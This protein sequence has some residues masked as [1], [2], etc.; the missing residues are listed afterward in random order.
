LTGIVVLGSYPQGDI[1]AALQLFRNPF[2]TKLADPGKKYIYCSR[3]SHESETPVGLTVSHEGLPTQPTH[4]LVSALDLTGN[5][6]KQFLEKYLDEL[7][8]ATN[9]R[10]MPSERSQFVEEPF[11]GW[12]TVRKY[13][14]I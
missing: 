1:A 5:V 12:E 9:I 8:Q 14:R 7:L 13:Y 6:D 11:R 2:D 3:V 10:E 4:I